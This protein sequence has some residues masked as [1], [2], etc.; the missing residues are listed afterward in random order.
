MRVRL[1]A[2]PLPRVVARPTPDALAAVRDPAT[3]LAIW[4]RP[5]R[6]R[7][8][9]EAAALARVGPFSVVAEARPERLAAALAT[10][11]PLH[12]PALLADVTVLARHFA[13]IA[14][15]IAVRARLEALTERGCPVFHADHVGLRLLVAYAGPGTEWVPEG[16]VN[17]AALGSGD[18]RAIVPDPRVIRRLPTFAAGIFKGEAFPGNR[19]RGIVHRSAPASRAR[20]RLLFCLDEPGQF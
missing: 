20:P 7:L 4:H 16:G 2:P 13:A 11:L 3:T 18:N 8:R 19:G 14:G 17:R 6:Q 1:E 5:P 9:C 10:S 12:A 15:V